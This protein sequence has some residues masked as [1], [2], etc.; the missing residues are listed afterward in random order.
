MREGGEEGV[1]ET[2]EVTGREGGWVSDLG[3]RQLGRAA[4]LE[5]DLIVHLS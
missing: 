2:R 5:A 4:W 1:R 3:I